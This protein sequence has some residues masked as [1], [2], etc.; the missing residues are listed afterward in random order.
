MKLIDQV[1]NTFAQHHIDLDEVR[2]L[3]A[4]SGGKDSMVLLHILKQLGAH[5]EVAHMNYQLRE[6]DSNLDAALVKTTCESLRITCHINV[7]DAK[8][9]CKTNHLSTQEGA[10]ILRYDWFE[11]LLQERKIDYITTAHHEADNHETFLQNVKR[12]SG[13]RG[14]KSMVFLQNNRCKPMLSFARITID[15]YA[16]ENAIS[17]RQDASNNQDHYQR[18]LIRNKVLPT[19]E[20]QLPGFGQ[21]LTQSIKHLQS[22]F[23]YLNYSLER[24]SQA[25]LEK[26][27]NQFIIADFKTHHPRLIWYV[28]EKFGFNQAQCQTILSASQTGK[29]IQSKDYEALMHQNDLIIHQPKEHLVSEMTVE[30]LGEY[31]CDANILRIFESTFPE[32]FDGNRQVAFVDFDKLSFPLEIRNWQ[33]GDKFTPLGMKGSKKLSDF[34]TD[35]K[36][37]LHEKNNVKVLISNQK[38]VWVI[39]QA[40]SDF[41][42]IEKS[43]KKVI[44]LET[45]LKKQP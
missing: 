29:T 21:G 25:M 15:Q 43:S 5:F 4:V 17:F 38:I 20:L 13:L 7:V 36:M 44:K 35:I 28:L 33:A 16:V 14:L 39:N 2:L 19:I 6:N 9:Y 45:I 22:D 41:F 31:D 11:Q 30:G 3:L 12:G 27:D 32:K 37:P 40:V 10:R 8:R 18:N 26:Q 34:L 1:K 23:D 42:K 24:D